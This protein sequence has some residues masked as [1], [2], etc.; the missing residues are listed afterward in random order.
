[1]IPAIDQIDLIWLI[2]YLILG[3]VL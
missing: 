3:K 2:Y 1:L